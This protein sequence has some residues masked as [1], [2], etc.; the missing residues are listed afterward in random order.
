LKEPSFYDYKNLV[1]SLIDQDP[2]ITENVLCSFLNTFCSQNTENI[3]N[4]E[5]LLLLI[6][7]RS[8]LIGDSIEF[9]TD[10]IKL[11]YSLKDIDYVLNKPTD[12]YIYT[13]DKATYKFGLP[14]K[15]LPNDNL[16][17]LLCDCLY[18]IND[19][20]IT[21][22]KDEL[23]DLLPALPIATIYTNLFEYYKDTKMFLPQINFTIS[24][25]DNSIVFFSR[26]ILGYNLKSFY[27]LEYILRKNLNFT[28]N[29]FKTLSMPECDILFKIFK[30]ELARL[31]KN[32]QKVDDQR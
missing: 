30:E 25:F 27:D 10:S 9:E 29:D 13:D 14:T 11:S 6:K 26:T 22:P 8:L 12:F 4:I 24:P 18:S 7:F 2:T 19:T 16:L 31:E 23:P 17:S 15:I 21:T 1:K 3:S 5:K 32:V 28:S 20:V